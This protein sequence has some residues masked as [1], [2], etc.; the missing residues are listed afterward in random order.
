M[1][2]LL[3]LLQMFPSQETV[4]MMKRKLTIDQSCANFQAFTFFI[5]LVLRIPLKSS[6]FLNDQFSSFHKVFIASLTN[7]GNKCSTGL[8]LPMK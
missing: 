5:G 7:P 1:L 6:I 4:I 3:L 2:L 8:Y